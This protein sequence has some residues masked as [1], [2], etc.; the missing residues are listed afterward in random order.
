MLLPAQEGHVI[1]QTAAG[2]Q[3][4]RHRS[5]R[6]NRRDCKC[7]GQDKTSCCT[8]GMCV[9]AR[10]QI[11]PIRSLRPCA[12]VASYWDPAARGQAEQ[13]DVTKLDIRVG[14]ITKVPVPM[15]AKFL[16]RCCSVDIRQHPTSQ[17]SRQVLCDVAVP[18]FDGHGAVSCISQ[19]WNHPDADK[20]FCEEI[21]VGEAVQHAERMPPLCCPRLAV[22]SCMG[23]FICRHLDRLRQGC[24]STTH[25]R[26]CKGGVFSFSAISRQGTWFN[27]RVTAWCCALRALMDRR[28]RPRS[29]ACPPAMGACNSTALHI[30]RSNSLIHPLARKLESVC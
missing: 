14:R 13:E 27:L 3:C 26:K 1:V 11:S 19:V 21:D 18:G 2:R 25:W 8:P 15:P 22:P 20:L 17:S 9:C 5:S 12:E 10:A 23:S 28:S 24:V 4:D 6:C 30:D 16:Y 7:E 29:P